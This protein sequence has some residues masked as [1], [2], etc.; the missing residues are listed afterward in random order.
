MAT[1]P[2]I[3]DLA[4]ARRAYAE[5]IV[6]VGAASAHDPAIVAMLRPAR[7][8]APARNAPT[9][10]PT[11]PKPLR[12]ALDP[13][14]EARTLAAGAATLDDLK[15]VIERFE[16][17]PL[18]HA[19]RTTVVCDGVYD[20]QVMAVGEAPGQEE[21]AQ[22]VPFV[23]RSGRLLDAMFAAI[24]LSRSANL[25][26]TNLIFWRPPNNRD[27][28]PEEITLCAPFVQR[29]IALKRPRLIITIGKP[30]TQSLLNVNDG[31]MRL[32]GR[33]MPYTQEGWPGPTPAVPILH[34]S[35]LLRRPQDKA[36]AW[37]DLRTIATLM[38]ELGIPRIDPM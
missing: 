32:R 1:L 2:P 9:T 22:G 18:K 16:H 5:F 4:R 38:D 30:A 33:R 27:P 36:R 34:P 19:A 24:G 14:A 21:D 12:R 23:G 6:D 35:Y 28:T 11:S 26:V 25:Y 17:C 7:P 29:Q 13:V 10:R 20:A 3:G 15:T 31:I 37:A 8:S